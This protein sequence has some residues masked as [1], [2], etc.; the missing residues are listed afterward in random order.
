MGAPNS[1]S[2]IV[3]LPVFMVPDCGDHLRFNLSHGVV[4]VRFPGRES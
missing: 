2:R 1:D 3:F 4:S